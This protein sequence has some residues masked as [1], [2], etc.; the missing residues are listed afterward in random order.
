VSLIKP[1]IYSELFAA[2]NLLP[3]G[4]TGDD[5]DVKGE[6]TVTIW[7]N[8]MIHMHKFLVCLFATRPAGSLL[9]D[10][11]CNMWWKIIWKS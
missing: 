3:F 2:N 7:F 5:L 9:M 11:C 6:K 4:L 10:F 1:G 8:N